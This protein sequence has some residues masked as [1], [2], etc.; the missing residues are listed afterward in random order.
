[1]DTLKRVGSL[2]LSRR[3]RKKDQVQKSSNDINEP[4]SSEY[5]LV[6]RPSY[7]TLGRREKVARVYFTLS[8]KDVVV[9]TL[10]G[11]QPTHLKAVFER[12]RKSRVSEA[13]LWEPS[14]KSTSTGSGVWHPPFVLHVAVSVPKIKSRETVAGGQPTT[15]LRH[16]DAFV[17]IGKAL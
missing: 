9:G 5:M 15:L 4:A 11:Y 10:N 1:M 8:F 3:G 17:S 7:G 14:L 2:R 16:K 6:P 13:V 12:R